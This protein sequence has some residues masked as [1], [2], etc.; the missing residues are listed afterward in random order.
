MIEIQTDSTPQRAVF[1]MAIDLFHGARDKLPREFQVG[2][3]SPNRCDPGCV[4]TVWLDAV[5]PGK[6]VRGRF[7]LRWDDAHFAQQQFEVQW[8]NQAVTSEGK[9][10]V[11]GCPGPPDTRIP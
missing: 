1:A 2:S 5:E 6:R 9:W 4:G 8:R 10:H 3:S 7:D 11:V